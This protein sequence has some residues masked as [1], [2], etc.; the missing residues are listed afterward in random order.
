M[1]HAIDNYNS[2]LFD[3]FILYAE[4]QTK[5]RILETGSYETSFT[6]LCMLNSCLN[7]LDHRNT[8]TVDSVEEEEVVQE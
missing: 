8:P 4:A 7:I 2:W 1:Q 6:C 3:Q 5:V